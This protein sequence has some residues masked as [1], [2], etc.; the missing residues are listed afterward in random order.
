MR[1]LA[2]SNPPAHY[3]N[4]TQLSTHGGTCTGGTRKPPSASHLSSTGAAGRSGGHV[5]DIGPQLE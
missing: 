2:Y 1:G 4:P 3:P 5:W